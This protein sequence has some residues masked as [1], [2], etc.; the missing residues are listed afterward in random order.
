[1]W[2]S[3]LITMLT[4]CWKPKNNW[5]H[6]C[7][8]AFFGG[9]CELSWFPSIVICVLFLCTNTCWLTVETS[10]SFGKRWAQI[11][12]QKKKLSSKVTVTSMK[13][14]NKGDIDCW[15]QL[16]PSFP[17]SLMFDP[18]DVKA[19]DLTKEPVWQGRKHRVISLSLA[20]SLFKRS[21]FQHFC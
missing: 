14:T 16:L 2:I 20:I 21:P 6:K 3:Y 18:V 5:T 12:E 10:D 17:P 13:W 7:F 11:K 19:G 8:T 15:V 4:I 9:H 1:M